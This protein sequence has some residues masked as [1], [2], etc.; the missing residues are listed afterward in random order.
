MRYPTSTWTW[1]NK[2]DVSTQWRA[3]YQAQSLSVSHRFHH[4]RLLKIEAVRPQGRRARGRPAKAASASEHCS[5]QAACSSCFAFAFRPSTVY[6]DLRPT[7][8]EKLM[9]CFDCKGQPSWWREARRWQFKLW[10]RKWLVQRAEAWPRLP[11]PKRAGSGEV[12]T[13]A[14]WVA[15]VAKVLTKKKNW[16][17]GRGHSLLSCHDHR[18]NGNT[19]VCSG[20]AGVWT[21][22]VCNSD[23]SS[24]LRPVTLFRL[25]SQRIILSCLAVQNRPWQM[26]SFKIRFKGPEALKLASS[27]IYV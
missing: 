24:L 2:F 16:K 8:R 18:K 22:Q 21:L 14:Q 11:Y 9:K 17:H 6:I 4:C 23:Y 5:W 20:L 25:S 1:L 15:V 10:L 19:S 13:V 12:C 7:T 27:F 3:A 26:A